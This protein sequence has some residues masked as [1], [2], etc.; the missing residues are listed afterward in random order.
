MWTH[1]SR[2]LESKYALSI[3]PK[4]LK[5]F[6]NYFGINYTLPKLDMTT[7]TASSQGYSAM[8]NWGLITYK[9]VPL[10]DID[11]LYVYIFLNMI[12]DQIFLQHITIH[13]RQILYIIFYLKYISNLKT[14]INFQRQVCFSTWQQWRGEE[15]SC[16]DCKSRNCT[17]VVWKLSHYV[18][19]GLV[20]SQ[21]SF[22]YLLWTV[23]VK[24]GKLII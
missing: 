5:Y 8:E 16:R 24:V 19:V 10:V 14:A 20:I 1:K 6:E 2:I 21:R 22:C 13:N 4:I 15:S 7:V 9:W 18:L 12:I 11:R 17:P 23:W 3:A